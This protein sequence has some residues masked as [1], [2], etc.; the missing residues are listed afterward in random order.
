MRHAQA[1]G[2][3]VPAVRLIRRI[4]GPTLAALASMLLTAGTAGAADTGTIRGRVLDGRTDRPKPGVTVVLTGVRSD[5]TGRMRDTTTTNHLGRYR[6]TKL[7]VAK[8]RVY[9][10]DANFEGGL[11][12]GGAVSLTPARSVFDTTLRVW[13]TT[14]DPSTIL[15][16]H[17]NQFLT[18]VAGGIDV[19]ESV[20]VVNTSNRAYIGRGGGSSTTRPSLGFALPA[21]AGDGGVQ[22]TSS[23]LDVPQ[24][25]RTGFGFAITAA[26]P[27]GEYLITF[28]YKVPGAGGNYDLSRTALYPVLTTA[29]HAK[30]PLQ[31]EG[32]GLEERSDV[33]IRG[34]RYKRWSTTEPLK[35]GDSL[36]ISA[37]ASAGGSL[38]LIAGIVAATA[39]GIGLFVLAF[40]RRSRARIA[41]VLGSGAHPVAETREHVISLIAA[42]DLRHRA[43]D[44]P[45][46]IYRRKRAELKQKL[47]DLS[48]PEHTR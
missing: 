22:I 32:T 30:D 36:Q 18:A 46:H 15:I 28:A 26:V 4:G 47:A 25:M 45:D 1:A 23:D 5:G 43:G 40:L 16:E 27:P 21:G 6:F 44:V 9:A 13:P 31:V 48:T 34:T 11:F 8:D 41:P 19:L 33:T 7:P 24:L 14:R 39:L 29:V 35:P 3:T 10:L 2:E 38:G 37:V 20:K 12:A 42:L 17:N